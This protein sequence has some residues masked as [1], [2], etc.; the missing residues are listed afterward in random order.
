MLPVRLQRFLSQ[1]GVCARRKA[2]WLITAGKVTVNNRVVTELGTKVDPERDHVMVEGKRVSREKHVYLLLNKPKGCV[3]TVSDPEGR[4]TVMELVPKDV[5]AKVAPV[6][7]LDFYTEGVLLLTNDGELADALLSPRKHVEKTYH[8]KIRGEVRREDLEK[9][10]AGVRVEGR[11]TKPAQVD[12]LQFT[13][14]HTWLV[15]TI[16]EGR[17]RQIHKMA[18]A[19]GYQVIKLA[20]VSFAGLT[21]YGLRIGQCRRLTP[22]EVLELRRGAGLEG[23]LERVDRTPDAVRKPRHVSREGP[24]EGLTER[25]PRN[26]IP[27]KDSAPRKRVPAPA[28]RGARNAPGTRSAPR[29][30]RNDP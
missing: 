27:G 4:A 21:Y 20:R 15:I 9:L 14:K 8:V 13:G 2:E 18:E 7:R 5:H 19:L 29:I 26:R 22:T 16:T 10:R 23:E 3:T 1:S 17:T 25:S 30:R 28:G 11:K 12:R 24:S 6:G